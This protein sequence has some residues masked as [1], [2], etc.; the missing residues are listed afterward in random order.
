MD[1]LTVY[2]DICNHKIDD[3]DIVSYKLD[4]SSD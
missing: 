4:N 1:Y 3:L 2:N